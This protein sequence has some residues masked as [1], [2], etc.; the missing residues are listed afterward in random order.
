[1]LLT[2]TFTFRSSN[3]DRDRG[4][5]DIKKRL[6]N[7][8]PKRDD[9][10]KRDSYK[11]SRDDYKT[12]DA[13]LPRHT[14]SSSYNASSSRIE[15]SSTLS[16]DRYS[17]IRPASD[18]RSSARGAIDDRESRNGSSSK[19]RYL[20]PSSS[21]SRF[22]DRPVVPATTSWNSS[23]SHQ[24]FGIN[25]ASVWTEKQPDANPTAWRGVDDAR[26]INRFP[27]NDRKPVVPA[28]QFI[29]QS[30]RSNQF[31]GSNSN[32]IPS[33]SRFSGNNNRYDNGRF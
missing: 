25:T 4:T 11:S 23:A 26:L 15:S 2:D 5:S 16:K 30:G 27:N 1:M 22:N 32:I 29:D 14:S 31:I 12:R 6:D 24:T 18:Y 17:D 8:Q 7:F 10:S 20:E 21:D 33:A 13:D 3:Y 19:P 9:Y 28:S